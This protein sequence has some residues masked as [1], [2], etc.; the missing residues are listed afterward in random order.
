M[1][2]KVISLDAK[3]IESSVLTFLTLV[4]VCVSGT[5]RMKATT[6][7]TRA[8]VFADF[9]SVG[10]H[11]QQ[12]KRMCRRSCCD[13]RL[14]KSRR[15]SFRRFIRGNGVVFS[16]FQSGAPLGAWPLRYALVATAKISPLQK[17]NNRRGKQMKIPFNKTSCYHVDL[18]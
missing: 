1:P 8:T 3:S 11:P 10:T 15:T 9:S 2:I 5:N 13:F 12:R 7:S 4:L 6:A 17:Y 14:L 18:G 16:V